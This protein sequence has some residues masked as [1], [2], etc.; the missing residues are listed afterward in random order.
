[1][2]EILRFEY[3]QFSPATLGYVYI[4]SFCVEWYFQY[5]LS[6]VVGDG[7][8][9]VELSVEECLEHEARLQFTDGEVDGGVVVAIM[10]D[11]LGKQDVIAS[12]MSAFLNE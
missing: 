10:V 1:M 8:A 7:D 3:G 9:C 12:E 5:A 2:F 11:K 4:E 6:D